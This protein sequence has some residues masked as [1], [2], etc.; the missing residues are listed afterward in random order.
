MDSLVGPLGYSSLVGREGS[1]FELFSDAV[2]LLRRAGLRLKRLLDCRR[3]SRVIVG[4]RA[5]GP[6]GAE[7]YILE[8][9]VTSQR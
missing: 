1:K 7:H 2:H 6:T 4:I 3:N 9:A 8:L 5:K